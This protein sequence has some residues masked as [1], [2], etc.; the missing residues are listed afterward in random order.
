MLRKADTLFVISIGLFFIGLITAPYLWA[1]HT[2][3][4]EYEFGGF[5]LNP[6]DGNS[7]LAKMYQGWQGSW[8]FH[9]PYTSQVGEGVPLFLYYLALGQFTRLIDGSLQITF[10]AARI[11]GSVL[12]LIAI[13]NFYG[14]VLPK[15][16]IKW[17]AFALALFG[18]GFGWLHL[19][20]VYLRRIFG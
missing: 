6:I 8:W 13:W 12:L 9:L 14:R 3:G 11:V 15:R 5:L 1:Y 16:R 17:L 18:S 4:S 19:S 2:A 7:Y 10:H 20:L